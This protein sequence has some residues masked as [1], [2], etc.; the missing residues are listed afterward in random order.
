[1]TA[2]PYRSC[3]RT[4]LSNTIFPECRRIM[5]QWNNCYGNCKWPDH[6]ASYTWPGDS[7]S[8][9]ESDGD[10]DRGGKGGKGGKGGRTQPKK[11]NG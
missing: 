2:T 4:G 5:G 8:E 9:S 11:G 10:R 6:A 3:A 7:E 1:M